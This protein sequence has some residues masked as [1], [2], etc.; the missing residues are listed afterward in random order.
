MIPYHFEYFWCCG[1]C[2]PVFVFNMINVAVDFCPAYVLKETP[3]ACVVSEVRLNFPVSK[4]SS[5]LSS[6]QVVQGLVN[7]ITFRLRCHPHLFPFDS[8][9]Y[10]PQ[11]PFFSI[12]VSEHICTRAST[13]LEFL[14]LFYVGPCSLR[15][16]LVYQ[17]SCFGQQR[18]ESRRCWSS[19]PRSRLCKRSECMVDDGGFSQQVSREA[20]CFFLRLWCGGVSK[21]DLYCYMVAPPGLGFVCSQHCQIRRCWSHVIH[22]D[23]PRSASL[24]QSFTDVDPVQSLFNRH[25]TSS[26]PVHTCVYPLGG[27]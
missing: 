16:R 1:R 22:L 3:V 14:F 5:L 10:C 6:Q 13:I 20:P 23:S 9:S 21:P 8:I 12:L 25:M 18:R 27:V 26:A 24:K 19:S 2:A 4:P 17:S 15:D 11:R 7:F